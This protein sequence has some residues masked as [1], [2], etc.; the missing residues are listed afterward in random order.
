M[1]VLHDSVRPVVLDFQRVKYVRSDRVGVGGSARFLSRRL[2]RDPGGGAGAG[3]AL[4][5]DLD[6]LVE[7]R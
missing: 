4:D 1:T 5:D 7:G 2:D 3:L 6:V